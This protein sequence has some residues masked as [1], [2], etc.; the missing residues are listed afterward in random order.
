MSLFE[1]GVLQGLWEG[2]LGRWPERSVSVQ[3]LEMDMERR[4][5]AAF[6]ADLDI[7][8]AFAVSALAG[9]VEA[10]VVDVH[11]TGASRSFR[12]R[13]VLAWPVG[14]GSKGSLV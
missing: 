6:T 9:L 4:D 5:A 2:W 14:L 3:G 1:G 7:V 10:S 8:R 12:S 11:A 13:L